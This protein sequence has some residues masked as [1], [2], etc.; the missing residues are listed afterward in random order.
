MAKQTSPKVETVD[1]NL[2]P[3]E[4]SDLLPVASEHI[5]EAHEWDRAF[6]TVLDEG[7]VESSVALIGHQRGGE[8][9]DGRWE[10][11]R[12][13]FRV[14]GDKDATEDAEVCARRDG[15]IYLVGS[16]YG[17]KSG[18]LEGKRAFLAR[19]REDDHSGAVDA[20]K[21]EMQVTLN[22]FRLHRA[23]NDA[24]AAFGPEL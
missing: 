20:P 12:P 3:N 21:V 1:L 10:T 15:W 24:L 7:A 18:P 17:G 22:K 9:E 11:A 14:K 8:E 16:H 23:V 4:A 13:R 5:L 2:H 6:W 19:F